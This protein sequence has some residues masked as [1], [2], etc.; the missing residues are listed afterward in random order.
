M[1]QKYFG[2]FI[3][4]TSNAYKFLF[5]DLFHPHYFEYFSQFPHVLFRYRS[6]YIFKI[7]VVLQSNYNQSLPYTF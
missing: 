4:K 2:I 3:I 6:S 7:E 5:Q 1:I